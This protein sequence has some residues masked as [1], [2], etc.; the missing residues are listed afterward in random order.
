LLTQ[1]T[2]SSKTFNRY[3]HPGSCHSHSPIYVGLYAISAIFIFHIVRSTA[4]GYNTVCERVR[5]LCVRLLTLS[6]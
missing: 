6:G 1:F 2:G 4:R 5:Y 3:H